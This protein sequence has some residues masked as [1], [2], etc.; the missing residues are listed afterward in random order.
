MTRNIAIGASAGLVSVLLF[1]VVAVGSSLSVLLYLV[2]PLPILI[3]ALGWRHTAG[4]AGAV[5]GMV[6][7]TLWFSPLAAFTFAL[8]AGIPGSIPRPSPL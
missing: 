6:L 3:V 2:A 1:S 5:T 7:A 4:I 8:V